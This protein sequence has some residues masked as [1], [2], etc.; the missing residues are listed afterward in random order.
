MVTF[1]GHVEFVQGYAFPQFVGC[2][3]GFVLDDTGKTVA[4]LTSDPRMQGLLE[5]ALAT[6]YAVELSAHKYTNPPNPNA[7]YLGPEWS[8]GTWGSTEVYSPA[9]LTLWNFKNF[10][11][12]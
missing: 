10:K 11:N 8:A 1:S 3:A 2:H 6:G 9:R 7:G 4:L 12:P 5:T